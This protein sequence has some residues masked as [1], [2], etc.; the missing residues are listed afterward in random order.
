MRHI[1]TYGGFELTNEGIKEWALATLVAL[2]PMSGK[3]Q[4]SKWINRAANANLHFWEKCRLSQSAGGGYS[5]GGGGRSATYK[6]DWKRISDFQSYDKDYRREMRDTKPE[7]VDLDMWAALTHEAG[8]VSAVFSNTDYDKFVDDKGLIVQDLSKMS[9]EEQKSIMY[10][11]SYLEPYF[12]YYRPIF[13]KARRVTPRQ[14]LEY[15]RS[16]PGGLDTFKS[17]LEHGYG[18]SQ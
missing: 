16:L 12:A 14:L 10:G 2:A 17:N 7:G 18:S 11:I 4:D 6:N 8:R 5:Y 13:P 15:Y 3:S 9:E 1:K